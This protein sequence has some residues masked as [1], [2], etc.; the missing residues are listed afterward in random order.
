MEQIFS[1]KN[2]GVESHDNDE[3]F[4]F[5]EANNVARQMDPKLEVLFNFF[6]TGLEHN[7]ITTLNGVGYKTMNRLCDAAGERL[8]EV[9]IKQGNLQ[10]VKFFIETCGSSPNTLDN[11]YLTSPLYNLLRSL[12]EFDDNFHASV[13]IASYLLKKGAY[14][15]S[16]GVYSYDDSELTDGNSAESIVYDN[17]RLE[18]KAEVEKLMSRLIANLGQTSKTDDNIIYALESFARFGFMP[19]VSDWTTNN[20]KD[21]GL[22]SIFHI[23]FNNNNLS[24]DTAKALQ[25]FNN[26]YIDDFYETFNEYL[27]EANSIAH[28]LTPEYYDYNAELNGMKPQSETENGF[29]EDAYDDED[30][31]L[32]EFDEDDNES[33]EEGD[34]IDYSKEELNE[35][36]SE[37]PD[38]DDETAAIVDAVYDE[39]ED[40][41]GED[42][43]TIDDCRYSFDEML[44]ILKRN[45]NYI[46]E[47]PE[48]ADLYADDI[49]MQAL[50]QAVA[51]AQVYFDF[52]EICSRRV[53]FID[54]MLA[55][56]FDDSTDSEYEQ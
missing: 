11:Y 19:K 31:Y 16:D 39:L 43:P 26:L 13:N 48:L 4:I 47:T 35:I 21:Y 32:D 51:T 29:S 36:L 45:P 38:Y 20:F 46:K 18:T 44:E 2:N 6:K 14:A 28:T 3:Q 23:D 52:Y 25:T 17:M 5:Y 34:K 24:Y 27:I 37:Y 56:R 33:F 10:A 15:Y 53:K 50:T 12:D 1:P 54:S 22:I 9:A 41:S 49:R 30:D 40:Y 8:I 42:E 55:K 7:M